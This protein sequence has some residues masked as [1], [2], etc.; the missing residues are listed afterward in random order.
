MKKKFILVVALVAIISLF[1]ATVSANQASNSGRQP[2]TS[3]VTNYIVQLDDAPLALYDGGVAG[4]A[5]TSAEATGAAF[6]LKAPASVAYQAYLVNAQTDLVNAAAAA[7]GREVTVV[8]QY[9]Y[10]INGVVLA[11]TPAEAAVV[12]NLSGVKQIEA[13]R[14]E[15]MVTDAGPEW[16]GALNVWDGSATGTPNSG[17][18]TVIAVLDSGINFDHPSFADPGPVDGY[19]FPA[20]PQY[21]GVCDAGDPQYN[22]AYTCNDKLIGAFTFVSEAV[23]PED[24]DGHGSHTASTAAGNIVDAVLEAPTI[25]VGA[26]VK[27]VAPHAH[28]I[29]MDVCVVSCPTSSILNAINKVVELNGLYPG[30]IDALNYS[31]SGGPLAWGDSVE[32]GFLSATATGV[33]VSASAGNN[34]P[35]PATAAHRSPWLTS[36]AAATSPRTY[37]TGVVDMSGGG[38]P[39]GDM[40]GRGITA[41]YGP[42]TI[43]YAGDY[44]NG[45][46]NPEQCLNPFPPGTWNGEIVVCDRG[47]IARVQKGANVLAGGAGGFVLANVAENGESTNAD[48]HFLPAAHIGYADAQVLEAWLAGGAG[49][50]AT[51]PEA[52]RV[53]NPSYGDHTA[54]FSSRGPNTTFDTIIPDVMAPGV[55]IYAAVADGLIPPDGE[56]EFDFLSGTSMSSPHNAGTG[57]LLRSLYPNW[58]P[59]QIQSA[60]MTTS[61]YVGPTKE[62]NVTPADPF[63]MGAG[64]IQVDWAAQ[65]GLI[66]NET[67]DNFINANPSLGGDPRTL[68]IASMA[69]SACTGTCSWTRTVEATVDGSWTATSI[70]DFP[71]TVEPANFTLMAGETQE[72]TI[73]A[74]SSALTPD[75]WA[76]ANVILTAD[77]PPLPRHRP[78]LTGGDPAVAAESATKAGASAPVGNAPALSDYVTPQDVLYDNGP[79]V[80]CAGCGAGG[81]DE[82]VLQ[83]TTLLMTTLGFGHQ[84]INGNRI[85]DD[86]TV[87]AAEGWNIDQITFFAYQTN[88][89]TNPSP[90]TAV[91]YQIW[92]GPPNDPGSSVVFGDTVTNRL[93]S[94]TWAN[95][96]RVSETTQGT[97]AR[98]VFANVASAGV[99][100][101]PGTY[102]LDWQTDGTLASGPWAP[103]ITIDGQTTTGNALQYTGTWGPANDGGT[104]TQQGFPFIIEG[105]VAGGG[106]GGDFSETSTPNIAIPDDAYDGSLG[107]MACDTIDASSIPAGALVSN[108]TVSLGATH[109]WIGDLVTKLQSPD[110]SILGLYSRPGYV[111]PLD[112]GQGCCGDSSNLD[113]TPLLFDDASLD[114][115]ET[116]GNTIG[117][118]DLVCTTDGRCDY[119]PNPGAVVGHSSFADFDGENASG[120]WMLCMGD[121]A[122]GDTGNFVEWTLNIEYDGGGGGGGIPEAHLPVAVVNIENAPDIEVSPSSLNS[123][124]APDTTTTVPMDISNNGTADLTWNVYE[125]SGVLLEGGWSDNFDSYPSNSPLHGVGGWK[126]WFNDPAAGASTSDAQ[127]L[128]SPNSVAI[129]GASDLVHEYSG[130]TSG[131]WNYTAWQ[132]VPTD[133]TGN[134][135]FIMLNTYND[136]GSGLNWS[137]QVQFQG[138]ANIVSNDGISGGTLP[139][140][141]GEWVEIR[142]E[143][144]LDNDTQTFFYDNQVLYSGTWTDEN[145]GGGALNIGAV[146]L[147]ANSASVIYYDDMSLAPTAATCDGPADISWVSVSPDNG[148]TTPGETSTVDVTFDSTGLGAGMYNGNLC[149]SSNDSDTP[150]VIVPVALEVVDAPNIDV[151]PLSLSSVQYT[152]TVTAQTLT[153]NNTGVTDLDWMI[154][155]ENLTGDGLFRP[156][157]PSAQATG[158][159][160]VAR[161]TIGD[162]D[163]QPAGSGQGRVVTPER[164]ATP[165]DLVT[166]THS[167]SQSIVQFNSVSCNA[168]GLHT[169]NSYLRE[170]DLDSFG[171]TNGLEVLEVEFGVEQAASGDGTGQPVSINLYTKINPAAPLTF[172]NLAPIGSAD[173]I[174]AD[175]ALTV[176]TVAVNGV[177]PAGSVLV[178][179]VFTPE[180]QTDGNSFFIGSNPNGETA[181]SYLAAAACGL[182]EPATTGSI[183]FPNMHIVMNVT[184]ETDVEPPACSNLAD[185]PWLSEDPTMG[186]TA[187]GGSTDVTVTFDSTGLAV[188]E[189]TANLCISSNDPD[190]GPGNGTDLVVVP[191]TLTVEAIPPMPAISLS[192]TV[193]TEAGVCATTDMIDVV[194]GTDVYYCYTVTNTGNVTLPLHDL[195]DSEL[196]DILTGFAYN[197]MPGESVSTVDAGLEISANIMVT[198]MNTAT[199]TA[200]DSAGLSASA[201]ASAT[202]NVVNPAISV[203]KTVGTAAGVC[204]TE[205]EITVEPGTDVYYCYTV[206][207][208]GDVTLPWH[209]LTD[210]ELGDIFMGFAYDLTPGGSVSTVDAGLEISATIMVTTTNTATWTAYVD[211]MI[212]ASAEASATVNV[213]EVVPPMPSITLSKTVGTEAGVCATE[214]M[215]TVPLNT[216][217]Y[218]CITVTNTGNVTL[219]L[220]DVSDPT[221]GVDLTGVAY[222]LEPGA[223]ASTVDLGLELSAMAMEDTT[224]VATWTAYVDDTVT[225]TASA[226]AMVMIEEPTDVSLSGFGGDAGTTS[227]LPLLLAALLGLGVSA[228]LVVRRRQQ[229]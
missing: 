185:V 225:A 161:V 198:T 78:V 179:E 56:D 171:L 114:D 11:L 174:V 87:D 72:L 222:D 95:I 200:Y 50:M 61:V 59:S 209:D 47:T 39:P 192:K 120:M 6:D 14:M 113:G 98:P 44:N 227:F 94:T 212:T 137:T 71:V 115:A 109:T 22:P 36:V 57:L 129:L 89:P 5:A 158:G 62:D 102:W 150:L 207:N 146:D 116:M 85:A 148:T 208:T 10:A 18:G 118:N 163:L 2:A 204:A 27:G 93:V 34:G 65:A 220:H 147:Y 58:S 8:A 63:D 190:P 143:I 157:F 111:E 80:N 199:W 186:T 112:D 210:S 60:L 121:S 160:N 83:S 16:I 213:E 105:S 108:V 215:L 3:G 49:H 37:E 127:A 184:G 123:S 177:A 224:N 195:T 167:A 136:A 28:I 173:V 189:Y 206:T 25:T 194:A 100:L 91:N 169:D 1:A 90:F 153:I 106:G 73:T 229:I 152:D 191:V 7:L 142:L 125:D 151:D 144:D 26:Q 69:N 203:T 214:S 181:P 48:P 154:D 141:K 124:Q 77:E 23:T 79:L 92:D 35:G 211:D 15:Q 9:Q 149:V 145:S 12:A 45:D 38:T 17:E 162:V 180:G 104:L 101:P 55:D 67:I 110:G 223:S 52:V 135:Y 128:S 170:F 164:S 168:G 20:P 84:L 53:I 138:A 126:G 217:V 75:V 221:L 21:F 155:E 133:F 132:Y 165:E 13:E 159:A 226:T 183:G 176:E 43:V 32:E 156:I 103:P 24:S 205:S 201:E 31:I 70:G 88:S 166:I 140:I 82:S 193:G 228:Y 74:D 99:T 130:Y 131:V 139:L 68:N 182:P 196:G 202:V 40:V 46:P 107:S 66:L 42:E 96:Y 51:I 33:F 117:S 175:Q 188:G 86:F 29:A 187:P 19:D 81:A 119:Y 178:V 41:G 216:M 64:R 122:G 30:L 134:S 218:Y 197:L 4:L 97:T 219:P 172:G 76:F 54:G